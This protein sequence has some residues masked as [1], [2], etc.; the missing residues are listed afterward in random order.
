MFGEIDESWPKPVKDRLRVISEN[1]SALQ[2]RSQAIQQAFTLE[3]HDRLLKQAMLA[4]TGAKRL[5]WL[6][7]EADLVIAAAK[8]FSGCSSG[9]SHCCHIGVSVCESEAQLIGRE[10]GVPPSRP[11]DGSSVVMDPD[12]DT[13]ALEE[14]A[15]ALKDEFRGVPCTFLGAD[16]RC[17]IYSSR[18][19][20]CRWQI[21]MD[22]DGLLCELVPGG[23]VPVPY[24]NTMEAKAAYFFAFGKVQRMSD[25]R[26][27]FPQG[28]G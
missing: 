6:R 1:A 4:T 3:Q 24:L 2:E 21:N 25:L 23:G 20:A 28:K 22:V 19:L 18:P 8:P 14:A 7:R 9:C 5:F 15:L 27:F 12:Q 16:G 11:P 17:Q 26:H 10:I 13:D